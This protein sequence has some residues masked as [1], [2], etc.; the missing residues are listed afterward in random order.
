MTAA[1]AVMDQAVEVS[2]TSGVDGHLEGVDG[3]V[4]AQ[5][6]RGLPP[7]DAAAVDVD[8]EGG[9]D[10]AAMRQVR[11]ATQSRLGSSAL[12]CRSTRSAGR[13]WRSSKRVVT[14]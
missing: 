12:N 9:V 1:V 14:L 8:D 7:D 4:A 13:C 11:S 3:Q 5:G 2:V 10:P 6:G